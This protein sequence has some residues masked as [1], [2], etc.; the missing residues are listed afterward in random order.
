MPIV[1]ELTTRLGYKID[2]RDLQKYDKQTSGLTTS[3]KGLATAA[4]AA[5]VALAG[6]ATGA[7]IKGIYDTNVEFEKLMAML[8]TA[9]G[10]V[11]LADEQFA[12][13]Q[14]FGATTPFQLNEVVNAFI[15][16]KN[17]GL[18]PGMAALRDYGNIATAMGKS[19]D[20][21]IEAVADAATGEFERLKEFGIKA[22]KQGDQV[23]FTFKGVKTTVKNDAAAITGYLR[24]ISEANFG[25]AMTD[26]MKTLPGLISNEG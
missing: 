15:K 24:S 13:L 22:S 20:Q 23:T 8:K 21:F 19:L 6:L 12:K 18:D 14:E 5:G 26:Q 9:T 10:S 17:L 25:T 7:L 3:L 2:D 16:L 11:K 4:A 1:R